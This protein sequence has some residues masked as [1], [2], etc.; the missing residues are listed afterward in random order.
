MTVSTEPQFSLFPDYPRETPIVD[1]D[2]NL[3]PLWDLGLGT[4][5]QTLQNNYSAQ[6]INIP[7]LS[8]TDIA[9]IQSVYTP[10]I[11][12][13]LPDNIPDITGTM[14]FDSTNLVPKIFIISYTGTNVATAAWKTFT[15]I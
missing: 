10:Y 9:D 6:G 15:L 8:A 7:L 14:V 13:A 3:T 2:G 12:S 5:F 4:L 11:G 1:K